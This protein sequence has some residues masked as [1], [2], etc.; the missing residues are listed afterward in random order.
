M[1]NE[2]GNILN[3]ARETLG[4]APIAE[5]AAAFIL[6]FIMAYFLWRERK[7]KKPGS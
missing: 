3:A 4:N 6:L 1:P 5:G 2:F 7:L